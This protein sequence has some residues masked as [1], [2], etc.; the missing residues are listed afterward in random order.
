M[1]LE[2]LQFLGFDISTQGGEVVAA[3]WAENVGDRRVLFTSS[4]AYNQ[5]RLGHFDLGVPDEGYWNSADNPREAFGHPLGPVQALDLLME[6]LAIQGAS[7]S[8]GFRTGKVGDMSGSG[9]QHGTLYLNPHML[10]NLQRMGPELTLAAWVQDGFSRTVMP[11]WR[12]SSTSAYG[13]MLEDFFGGPRATARAV[14][15]RAL[16]SERFSVLQ[17]WKYLSEDPMGYSQTA[18]VSLVSSFM[19]SLLRGSI[20]PWDEGDGLGTLGTDRVTK[21]LRRDLLRSIDSG[22]VGRI[23]E[24][25]PVDSGIG[26]LCHYFEKYGFRPDTELTIWTGDNINSLAGCG[27]IGRAGTLMISLGSSDTASRYLAIPAVSETAEGHIFGAPDGKWMNLMCWKN[28][29]LTRGEVAL[30]Y[31]MATRVGDETEIDWGKFSD[32]LKTTEPGNRGYFMLPY[33]DTEI[34]PVVLDRGIVRYGGLQDLHWPEVVKPNVRACVE[35]QMLAM[36]NHTA[37]MGNL[38]ELVVTGGA[39]VNREI[40]QVMANVFDKPVYSLEEANSAAMGAMMRAAHRYLNAHG[41]EVSWE[42]MAAS[43]VRRVAD[44][45]MPDPKAAAIYKEMRPVYQACED[46]RVLR[47]QGHEEKIEAFKKNVLHMRG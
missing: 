40:L 42:E 36:A 26:T 24:T 37:Y 15:S 32:A 9:M 6:N 13:K 45:V 23:P 41:T 38:D 31:G 8:S 29:S 35:A 43:F 11:I 19:A 21:K 28:G 18:T 47:I 14:G 5:E 22:L 34:T 39:S 2:D 1:A 17:I 4:A 33:Y 25:L 12:D 46:H 44:P 16:G 30:Q 20:V 10:G 7:G 3:Q 27:L